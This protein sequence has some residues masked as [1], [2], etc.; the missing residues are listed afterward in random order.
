M[1]AMA[2]LPFWPPKTGI[3]AHETGIFTPDEGQKRAENGLSQGASTLKTAPLALDIETY[4]DPEGVKA[5]ALS[6]YRRPQARHLGGLGR[7]Y[8]NP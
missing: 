5:G 6:P 3:F 4:T 7:P 8:R 2:K 1:A